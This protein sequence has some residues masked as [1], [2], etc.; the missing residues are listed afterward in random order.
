MTQSDIEKI[1]GTD[2]C[3]QD[4]CDKWVVRIVKKLIASEAILGEAEY[5]NSV[6]E[7]IDLINKTFNTYG[8]AIIWPYSGHDGSGRPRCHSYIVFSTNPLEAFCG[9]PTSL[10]FFNEMAIKSKIQET[11]N[12]FKTIGVSHLKI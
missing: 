5:K 1:V 8:Y 12:V 2:Y 7:T 9:W 6:Q 3:P 10:V 4:T 11:I